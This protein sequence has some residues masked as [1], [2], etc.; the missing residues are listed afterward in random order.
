MDV[1]FTIDDTGG[2][3]ITL[4]FEDVVF[5]IPR[6][7]KGVPVILEEMAEKI[8]KVAAVCEEVMPA[9]VGDKCLIMD[10]AKGIRV[11]RLEDQAHI[12]DAR[13]QTKRVERRC[14][15]AGM[16]PKDLR[17]VN[18]FYDPETEKISIVDVMNF[19]VP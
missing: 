15:K 7:K 14:E 12:N 3:F 6:R 9:R 1:N 11:D 2:S 16:V 13:M 19:K 10:R 5:K 17:G 8:N 18:V 4:V